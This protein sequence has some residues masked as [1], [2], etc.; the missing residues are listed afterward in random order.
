LENRDLLKQQF[1]DRLGVAAQEVFGRK[2]TLLKEHG[3]LEEDAEYLRPTKTGR[4]FIDE[5]TQSFY[6]PDFLP[7]PRD[8]YKDGPLNPY[9]DNETLS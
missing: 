6:H 3:L 7:F 4:F 8:K 9:L 1:Q 5:I 2:I